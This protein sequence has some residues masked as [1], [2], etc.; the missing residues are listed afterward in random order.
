M[1]TVVIK[2]YKTKF[3]HSKHPMIMVNGQSL[4]ELLAEQIGDENLLG[5][6]PAAT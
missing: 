5:L 3:A 6:V 2:E 1:D 4:D